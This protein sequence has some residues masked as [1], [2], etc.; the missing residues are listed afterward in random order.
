MR[1]TSIDCFLCSPNGG[2]NHNPGL[3]PDWESNRG[4]LSLQDDAQPTVSHWS[5]QKQQVERYIDQW[6]LAPPTGDL[7]C[8]PGMGPDWESDR[9]PFGWQA[10]AQSTE[11]HQPGQK[12]WVEML[13]T[14]KV[15]EQSN[16]FFRRR[17]QGDGEKGPFYFS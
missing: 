1:E 5:G 15:T 3:C 8:N 12:Q 17:C 9:R 2:S 11:P 10:S 7:A 6:P 13:K 16:P 4:P 14:R